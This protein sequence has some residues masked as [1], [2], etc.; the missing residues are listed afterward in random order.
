[1]S[2]MEKRLQL[3]LDARRWELVSREAEA[4]HRSA[5][6]VIREAI[7]VYFATDEEDQRRAEAARRFLKM[8]ESS[9]DSPAADTD[10]AAALDDDL[11]AYL[12]KKLAR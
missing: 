12:D 1:M 9:G 7:D 2:V 11:N 4:G 5:A 6:S 3:L 8:T 10:I